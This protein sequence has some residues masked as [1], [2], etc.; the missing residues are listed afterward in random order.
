MIHKAF[1]KSEIAYLY[2]QLKYPH[3][4]YDKD[5][6]RKQFAQDKAI[7]IEVLLKVINNVMNEQ[8]T[9]LKEIIDNNRITTL[10]KISAIQNQLK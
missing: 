7:D 8:L 1:T 10:E 9:M 2:Y 4:N 3:R 6:S 5:H